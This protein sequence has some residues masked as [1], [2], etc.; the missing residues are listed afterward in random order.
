[1]LAMLKN[2]FE[3]CSTATACTNVK[4][5]AVALSP[6]NEEP[7]ELDKVYGRLK[8]K[9]TDE[10]VYYVQEFKV[11]GADK[12]YS[13]VS[14]RRMRVLERAVRAMHLA[15]PMTSLF[16]IYSNSRSYIL[17]SRYRQCLF[18]CSFSVYFSLLRL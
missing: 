13:D 5:K 8:T 2:T 10:I 1:M 12:E 9:E 11:A 14:S 4:S 17:H 6:L 3:I 18:I 15:P 16:L 7:S